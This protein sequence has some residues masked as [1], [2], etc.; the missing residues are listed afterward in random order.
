MENAS[1]FAVLVNNPN[2]TALGKAEIT[3]TSDT[4]NFASR[5]LVY[6]F[7]K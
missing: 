4:V 7:Q 3:K 5:L 6:N 2:V 1:R